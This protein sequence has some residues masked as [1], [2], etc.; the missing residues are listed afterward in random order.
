MLDVSG[1]DNETTLKKRNNR[2]VTNYLPPPGGLM[3]A[4]KVIFTIYMKVLSL[5]YH[6]P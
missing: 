2:G 4:I 5:E 3:Q 1:A 6:P